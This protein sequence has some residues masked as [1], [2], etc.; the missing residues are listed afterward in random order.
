MPT[1]SP[2]RNLLLGLTGVA[3]AAV[4]VMASAG[5]RGKDGSSSRLRLPDLQG[6]LGW[7]FLVAVLASF[8]VTFLTLARAGGRRGDFRR[9]SFLAQLAP[10][11]LLLVFLFVW[12]FVASRD[13]DDDRNRESQ[14]DDGQRPKT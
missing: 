5:G 11:V 2:R 13:D 10:L 7:V 1:P 3:L 6:A 14:S 9:R 4:V 8:V 12:A